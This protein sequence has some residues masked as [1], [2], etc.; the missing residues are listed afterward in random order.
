MISKF[1]LEFHAIRKTSEY[2]QGFKYNFQDGGIV[3]LTAPPLSTFPLPRSFP[4]PMF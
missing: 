4:G 1:T 3:Q 2:K